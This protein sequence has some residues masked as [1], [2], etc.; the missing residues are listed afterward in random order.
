MTIVAL[1][2]IIGTIIGLLHQLG[3]L[4]VIRDWVKEQ[5]RKSREKNRE[6]NRNP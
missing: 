3:L 1:L 4:D 2:A 6:R 5:N